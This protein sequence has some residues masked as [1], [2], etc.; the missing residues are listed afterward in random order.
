MYGATVTPMPSKLTPELDPEGLLFAVQ[1]AE[2][3]VGLDDLLLRGAAIDGE[4]VHPGGDLLLQASDSLH[5]ELVEDGPGDGEELH[6]LEEGGP[7]V[8]GL[9]HDAANEREP[10]QLAIEVDLGR[11]QVEFR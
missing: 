8:V 3:L 9:V 2:D 7:L 4:L 10:G 5:E 1:V 11:I 6:A